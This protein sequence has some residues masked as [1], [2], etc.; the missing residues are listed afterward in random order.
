MITKL[1][2]VIVQR[3]KLFRNNNKNNFALISVQICAN[4]H[5]SGN[6]TLSNDGL[7]IENM[8]LSHICLTVQCHVLIYF[9]FLCKSCQPIFGPR[10]TEAKIFLVKSCQK[11]LAIRSLETDA[12]FCRYCGRKLSTITWSLEIFV[13]TTGSYFCHQTMSYINNVH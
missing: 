5:K 6:N 9:H 4:L 3:L 2:F 7:I 10:N 1:F 8:N 13:Q 11:L 12:H